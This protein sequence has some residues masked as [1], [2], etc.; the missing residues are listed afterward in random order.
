MKSTS[1]SFVR[2]RN[3]SFSPIIDAFATAENKKLPVYF[4]PI[5]DP[6]AYAVDALSQDWTGLSMYA[7]PPT[8]ILTKVLQRIASYPLQGV[9]HSPI[10]VLGFGTH[11]NRRSHS[12]A[13]YQEAVTATEEWSF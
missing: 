6:E 11:V 5:P 2:L 10:L 4:S 7:F 12:L 8:A 13:D 3:K 1:A 9:T